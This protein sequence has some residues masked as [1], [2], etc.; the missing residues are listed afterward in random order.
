MT[1]GQLLRSASSAELTYWLA[2]YSLEPFGESWFQT[3][4]IA[5]ALVNCFMEGPP[6]KPADFMPAG[7]LEEAQTEEQEKRRIVAGL[8][9]DKLRGK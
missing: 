4:T 2:Y 3:G 5:S 8:M 9:Q 1:V 7:G 6:A